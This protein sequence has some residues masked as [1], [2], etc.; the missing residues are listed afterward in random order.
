[1]DALPWSFIRLKLNYI[2]AWDNLITDARGDCEICDA[3]RS[4]PFYFTYHF[5]IGQPEVIDASQ[6]SRSRLRRG[7][8]HQGYATR[9][10]ELAVAR[11]FKRP[12]WFWGPIFPRPK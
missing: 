6:T 2:S 12:E 9:V 1:M 4:G 7:P 3:Q 11:A 10:N 8:R 5:V